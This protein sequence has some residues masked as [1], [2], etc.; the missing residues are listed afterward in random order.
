MYQVQ[1]QKKTKPKKPPKKTHS[2]NCQTSRLFSAPLSLSFFP[3][4]Y[5]AFNVCFLCVVISVHICEQVHLSAKDDLCR[6]TFLAWVKNN[7][8]NCSTTKIWGWS[9]DI[10]HL[11]IFIFFKFIIF[12]TAS[13][14][15]LYKQFP[16]E[17]FS[18]FQRFQLQQVGPAN[19][20]QGFWLFVP[21]DFLCSL[22]L[23]WLSSE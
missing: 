4:W 11:A 21:K 23:V 14:D 13:P 5:S 22:S 9:V 17:K 10:P 2:T 19:G 18:Q 15:K 7:G 1:Y 12:M 3:K 6:N 16:W 8:N 20:Q